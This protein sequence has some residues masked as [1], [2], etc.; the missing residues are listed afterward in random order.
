MSSQVK[1][2][3]LDS[4]VLIQAWQKYYSPKLCHS[5]WE[6]L[7]KLGNEGTIYISQ[8]VYDELTKTDDDL[9]DWVKKSNI[10]V[11]PLTAAVTAPQLW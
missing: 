6:V 7:N 1:T 9:S 11:K 3:C 8:M 10:E 5:Y 4:N 2:Y